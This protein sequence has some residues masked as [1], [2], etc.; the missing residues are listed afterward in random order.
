MQLTTGLEQQQQ[1]LERKM[2]EEKMK[3]TQSTADFKPRGR[4]RANSINRSSSTVH[5]QRP[6]K[7][8]VNLTEEQQKMAAMSTGELR[9]FFLNKAYKEWKHFDGDTIVFLTIDSF[10]WDVLAYFTWEIKV[11]KVSEF[12]EILRGRQPMKKKLEWAKTTLVNM[13]F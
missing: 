8:W 12:R 13:V 7:D 3:R 4:S 11:R 1:E 10:L 9:L 6:E 5:I 2:R